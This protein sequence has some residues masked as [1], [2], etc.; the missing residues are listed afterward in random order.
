MLVCIACSY[1]EHFQYQHSFCHISAVEV[2]TFVAMLKCHKNDG[3]TELNT[4][5]F[6]YASTDLHYHVALL[7]SAVVCHGS[8]PND[9]LLVLLRFQNVSWRS[10]SV[11]FAEKTSVFGSV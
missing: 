7:L 6:K 3:G 2:G 5:H 10:V 1:C 4:N 9:F 11:G 8:V